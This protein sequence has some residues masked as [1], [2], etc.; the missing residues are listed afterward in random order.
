MI[1]GYCYAN[2]V[3]RRNDVQEAPLRCYC[4][5]DL[6]DRIGGFCSKPELP[7]RCG[8]HRVVALRLAQV[9]PDGLARRQR[10][11]YRRA[12]REWRLADARQR[13]SGYCFLRLV[14]LRRRM[15]GGDAPARR[16]DRRRHEG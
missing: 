2:D 6:R 12:E 8:F 15:P 5:C 9:G 4:R 11:D 14:S 7:P 1:L 10:R 16:E 13:L 3:T